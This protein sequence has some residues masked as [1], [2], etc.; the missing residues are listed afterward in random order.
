MIDPKVLRI[1]NW[2]HPTGRSKYVVVTGLLL[3]M[4]EKNEDLCKEFE[5]IELTETLLSSAGFKRN[6]NFELGDICQQWL[7]SFKIKGDNT[8]EMVYYLSS[9]GIDDCW[10]SYTVNDYWASNHFKY[11]HELQNLYFTITGGSELPLPESAMIIPEGV[12]K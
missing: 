2:I 6:D 12:G 11:L 3:G 7:L 5:G 4:M 8:H 10:G 9:K 1:G